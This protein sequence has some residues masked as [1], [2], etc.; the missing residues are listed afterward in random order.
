M[1]IRMENVQDLAPDRIAAFLEGSAGIEFT[2][3][4]R[5]ERYAWVEA[6]LIEQRYFSLT[7]KQ[8]GGCARC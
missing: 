7:K 3:Q 4:S 8:R 2:G 5:T 6:T 1:R